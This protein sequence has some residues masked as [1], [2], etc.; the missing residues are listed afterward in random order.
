MRA[1]V[2]ADGLLD[3]ALGQAVLDG[4]GHAAQRLDLGDV[5]QRAGG[6]VGGQALDVVAAAPGI[7]DA[8]LAALGLQEELGVA[9]DPGGEVGRQGKGLVQ[10]VGVQALG[11]AADR[12]H[13]LDGGARR[14]C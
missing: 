4:L 10:R 6:Q 13:G 9:A 14:R 11:L 3:A 5:G 8:G 12:G 2:R 7:D 1:W